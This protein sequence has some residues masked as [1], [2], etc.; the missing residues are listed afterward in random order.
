MIALKSDTW[1]QDFVMCNEFPDFTTF[2][3]VSESNCIHF[4][5]VVL[6]LGLKWPPR[7]KII[8]YVNE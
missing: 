1:I 5:T 4:Y 7:N 3:Q 8:T 2:I 6:K